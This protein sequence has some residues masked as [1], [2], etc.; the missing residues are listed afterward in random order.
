M[1]LARFALPLLLAG[2]GGDGTEIEDTG[3]KIV[4]T[5]TNGGGVSGC[6]S[7]ESPSCDG[8]GLDSAKG[9]HFYID[10]NHLFVNI[11]ANNDNVDL[12]FEVVDTMGL[13][14]G[15]E[16]IVPEQVVVTMYDNTDPDDPIRYNGCSGKLTITSYIAGEAIHGDFDLK[17]STAGGSCDVSQWYTTTGSFTGLAFCDAKDD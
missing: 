2:C 17:A 14:D 8:A 10:S 16:Y 9:G 13:V 15:V 5:C 12:S 7:Y 4:G 3:T 1:K 6:I 11:A